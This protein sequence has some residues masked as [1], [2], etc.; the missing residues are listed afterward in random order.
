VAHRKRAHCSSGAQAKKCCQRQAGP[1]DEEA[2]GGDDENHG[3]MEKLV[4]A[5]VSL[6][7]HW[8]KLA[9]V[10]CLAKDGD[11][12]EKL[13]AAAGGGSWCCSGSGL[14]SALE[15]TSGAGCDCSPVVDAVVVV[16]HV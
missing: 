7:C 5:T 13:L 3:A 2:R 1:L 16:E 14:C 9:P 15:G 4:M 8:S 10:R 11:L 12:D 6:K